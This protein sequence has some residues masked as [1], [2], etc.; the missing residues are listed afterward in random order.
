MQMTLTDEGA[1][2][3]EEVLGASLSQLRRD[4]EHSETD[5]DRARLERKATF[6]RKILQQLAVRGLSHIV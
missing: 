3:L 1:T 6:I 2:A 4:I 5:V